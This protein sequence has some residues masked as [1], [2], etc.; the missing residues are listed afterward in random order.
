[1]SPARLAGSLA[2]DMMGSD[3]AAIRNRPPTLRPADHRVRGALGQV[4]PQT[5]SIA[6]ASSR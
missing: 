1:V 2:V 6:L 3:I 5:A 4:D